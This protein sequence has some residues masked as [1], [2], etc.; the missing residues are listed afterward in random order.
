MSE[1]IWNICL[2]HLQNRFP[3]QVFETWL[4][5]IRLLSR[6]GNYIELEVPN[7]FF[8]DWVNENYLTAIHDSLFEASQTEFVIEFRVSQS[9]EPPLRRELPEIRRQKVQRHRLMQYNLI[10]KYTFDTFVAGSSNQFAHAAALAVANMPAKTYNPLFIYG[11]VGLGKT[12]LLNAI[13]HKILEKYPQMRIALISS[14]RFTNELINSIRYERGAEFREKYRSSCDVLMIDDIQFIAGKER[15]QEEFFHTFNSLYESHKQIV[16]MSDKPPKE[17]PGFEERLRSRFEWGLVAD[18]QPPEMETKVAILKKKAEMEGIHLPNDVAIYLASNVE[19]NVRELE[20]SLIRIGAF[21]SLT[22]RE[23][24]LD[25]AKEVLQETL[26]KKTET[27]SISHIQKN[28]ANFFNVSVNDLKSDR[29]IRFLTRP[30]QIAMYLSR[31]LTSASFPEIGEKFG[32]KDH[33]TVI[34]AVR[35]VEQLIKEDPQTR[36]DIKAIQSSF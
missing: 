30:R 6:N 15:T 3:P 17:M 18:I 12:H 32:G 24:N 25:L 33:S 8:R 19:S 22:G 16:I 26:P 10:E 34:H 23:I 1:E 9:S 21:S 31:S 13:G 14:E 2:H 20:G 29:K 4:K 5:P 7:K 28:V 11:G 27:V 35:K 36:A